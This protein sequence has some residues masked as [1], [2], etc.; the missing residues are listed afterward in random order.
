MLRILSHKLRTRFAGIIM[1]VL[2]GFVVDAVNVTDLIPN[3]VSY[4]GDPGF[5]FDSPDPG[6]TV[7]IYDGGIQQAGTGNTSLSGNHKKDELGKLVFFDQDSPS[8]EVEYSGAT[9]TQHIVAA[10]ETVS[11]EQL[12]YQLPLYLKNR[13]ILI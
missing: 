12:V 3:S 8:L 7:G 13:S 2:A 4:H 9:V 6:L 5:D 11:V 10:P 1:L